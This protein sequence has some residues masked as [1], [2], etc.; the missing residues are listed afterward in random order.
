LQLEL[1]GLLGDRLQGVEEDYFEPAWE[2]L[3]EVG[4]DGLLL[5]VE[6]EAVRL[7]LQRDLGVVAVG[8]FQDFAV[9]QGETGEEDDGGVVLLEP[10]QVVAI[11]EGTDDLAAG[12]REQVVALLVA[13]DHS[14]RPRQLL[15][16]AED[17]EA[18]EAGFVLVEAVEHFVGQFDF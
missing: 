8:F 7:D 18:S 2:V 11:L 15:L 12:P 14:Q 3:L 16:Q 5:V 9:G 10:G 17:V 6:V 1:A 13:V 4:C